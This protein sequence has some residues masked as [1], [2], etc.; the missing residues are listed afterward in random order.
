MGWR[1]SSWGQIRLA[2]ALSAARTPR[3]TT[4]TT[5]IAAPLS[6]RNSASRITPMT[7]A[8]TRKRMGIDTQAV[9]PQTSW[10]CQ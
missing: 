2:A 5:S 1:C 3:E 8:T 4:I 7:G 6:G 9:S 10:S